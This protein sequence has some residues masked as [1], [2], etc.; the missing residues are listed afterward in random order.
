MQNDHKIAVTDTFDDLAKKVDVF[1]KY[2]I[3]DALN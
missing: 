1:A 3:D 2:G